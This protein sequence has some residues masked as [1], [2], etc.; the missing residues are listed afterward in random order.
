MV[1]NNK[2]STIE[3]ELRI[4]QYVLSKDILSGII[5]YTII[6]EVSF[7]KLA[8]TW[9]TSFTELNDPMNIGLHKLCSM[10][11]DGVYNESGF[12]VIYEKIQAEKLL[13]MYSISK[14]RK[15]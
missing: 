1:V 5:E 14:K 7:E 9:Y 12:I 3:N 10:E 4:F 6:N 15:D 13:N 2:N 11:S 8:V